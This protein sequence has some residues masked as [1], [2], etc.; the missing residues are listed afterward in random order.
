VPARPVW[1]RAPLR[2]LSAVF[3]GHEGR[4]ATE[5]IDGPA[6]RQAC[7]PRERVGDSTEWTGAWRS[8]CRSERRAATHE[9][10]LYCSALLLLRCQARQS[11]RRSNRGRMSSA[12]FGRVE[13]GWIKS[14]NLRRGRTCL[15]GLV[16]VLVPQNK[17]MKLTR[18]AAAPGTPTQGAAAWPR[19]LGT[20]ATASQLIRGVR[21][22]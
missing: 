15:N 18:L 17:R 16:G 7:P 20:G 1:T 13:P 9:P 22:T 6:C 14:G 8:A 12:A 21:P 11:C 2:S 10:R 3:C 19:R 5:R 4:G